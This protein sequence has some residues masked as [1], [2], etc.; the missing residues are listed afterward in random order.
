MKFGVMMHKHT[1]NIGDDIQTFA[2][3]RLLPELTY[4]LDRERLDSFVTEDGELLS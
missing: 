1:Q 2:A 4:F 3:A